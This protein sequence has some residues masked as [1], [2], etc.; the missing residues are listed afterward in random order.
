MTEWPRGAEFLVAVVALAAWP[1]HLA[2]V[3]MQ[4]P[5]IVAQITRTS[6]GARWADARRPVFG[7][8]LREG[9]TL[10][11]DRGRVVMTLASG[12]QIG[13]EAPAILCLKGENVVR[14]D[15]GRLSAVVPAQA[16]GF[17]VETTAGRVVD[18]GTEFTLCKDSPHVLRLFVFVGLVEIQPSTS[19][20]G[21]PIR[22]PESRGVRFDG[23]TGEVTKIPFDGIEM[24]A[25]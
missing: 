4:Q 15:S 10:S 17:V 6:P 24:L 16:T 2:Y 18:L 5:A 22:V 14:L 23:K 19:A 8:F 1:L 12:A 25:P 3:A 7:R 21:K 13:V 20:G 11:V 9:P